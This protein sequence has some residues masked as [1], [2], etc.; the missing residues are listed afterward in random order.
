MIKI[1]LLIAW[2]VFVFYRGHVHGSGKATWFGIILTWAK[3][4]FLK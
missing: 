4:L 1:L 3:A 2:T